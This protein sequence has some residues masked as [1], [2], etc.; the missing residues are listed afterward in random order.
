MKQHQLCCFLSCRFTCNRFSPKHDQNINSFSWSSYISWFWVLVV[1]VLIIE[2]VPF[3]PKEGM[4]WV[5]KKSEVL[6]FSERIHSMNN[7]LKCSV[8][9]TR[10]AIVLLGWCTKVFHCSLLFRSNI[11]GGKMQLEK[12]FLFT[13][14]EENFHF[15]LK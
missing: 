8:A 3:W 11:S 12:H 15:L 14:A 13:I 5:K 10:K 2:L 9:E 7:K 1:Q 6:T 4:E